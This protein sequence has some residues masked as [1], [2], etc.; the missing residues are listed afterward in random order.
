MNESRS[1][2]ISSSSSP[3]LLRLRMVSLV[4]SDAWKC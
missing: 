3:N 4:Y 2:D 1:D